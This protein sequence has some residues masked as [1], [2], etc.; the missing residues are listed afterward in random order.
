PCVCLDV[1]DARAMCGPGGLVAPAALS[2]SGALSGPGVTEADRAGFLVRA[3][4]QVLGLDISERREL[5]ACGRV[6]V[7]ARYGLERSVSRWAAHFESL[8]EGRQSISETKPID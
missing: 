5:G 4:G 6:H 2:G 3:L 8:S 7:L 1:G